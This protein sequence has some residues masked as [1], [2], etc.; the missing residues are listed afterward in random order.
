MQMRPV[1]PFPKQWRL[2]VVASLVAAAIVITMLA[3]G[4]TAWAQSNPQKAAGHR[5][6]RDVRVQPR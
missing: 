5:T 1:N 2:I 4:T 3:T 6:L